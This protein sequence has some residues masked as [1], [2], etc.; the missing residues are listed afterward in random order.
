MVFVFTWRRDDGAIDA[1]RT[2]CPEIAEAFVRSESD[3]PRMPVELRG[4][5]AELYAHQRGRF[6]ELLTAPDTAGPAGEIETGVPGL[7]VRV[8]RDSPTMV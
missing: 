8:E 7:T 4:R 3:F 5:L 1:F 2:D 6:A